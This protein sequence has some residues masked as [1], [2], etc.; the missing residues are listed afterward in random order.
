MRKRLLDFFWLGGGSSNQ[1]NPDSLSNKLLRLSDEVVLSGS[2]VS[3]W[4]DKFNSNDASNTV[5]LPAYSSN[6][7]SNSKQKLSFVRANSDLLIGTNLALN[8]FTFFMVFKAGNITNNQ[9]VFFE[10]YTGAA[11]QNVGFNIRINASTI[12]IQCRNAT[13]GVNEKTVSFTDTSSWHILTVRFNPVGVGTS[14]L[15]VRVDSVEEL[16]LSNMRPMSTSSNNYRVGGVSGAYSDI[17][18]SEIIIYSDYKDNDTVIGIENYLYSYY[19][20]SA[21]TQ[22]VR[23]FTTNSN[24]D[25]VTSL[26]GRVSYNPLIS[27]QPI[28]VLMAGWDQSATDFD[29]AVYL[30]FRNY[31]CFVVGVGM[32]GRNGASGSRDASGRELYDIYDVLSYVTSHFS[33]LVSQEKISIVGYSGGGGNV[34]GMASKFP[35]LFSV[36]VNFFPISDYGYDATYGW[37]QQEPSR[38]AG[39]QS[40]IGDTPTNVPNEYKSRQH[41]WSASNTTGKLWFLHDELDSIVE[42]NHT[43]ETISQLTSD[44]FTNYETSIT[45][46]GDAVRWDHELPNTGSD[47]IQAEDLFKSDLLTLNKNTIPTSGT[48]KIN[49]YLKCSLF[50]IW[51]GNGTLAQDGKNRRATLTYN[52]DTNS[53]TLVP[54]IDSPETDLTYDFEDNIGRV[55]SGTISASTPFTPS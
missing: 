36:M 54:S 29:N 9:F 32:R 3:T 7:G 19:A 24:I 48:L 52:Y 53:Y 10:N 11:F 33:N 50:T 43:T 1:I 31:G 51:L 40:S 2:D 13:D 35:D 22:F 15:D 25:A 38:Q 14:I 28:V 55:S 18:I 6:G 27:N 46:S 37:Y 8:T 41:K 4:T 26:Y 39:L 12:G 47:V 34:L 44:G 45:N 5:T 42:Y 16:H 21:N 20:L 17:E 49:G 30:R 23:T